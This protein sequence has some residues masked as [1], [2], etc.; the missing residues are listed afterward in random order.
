MEILIRFKLSV[1]LQLD[2]MYF[3][4]ILLIWTKTAQ[5]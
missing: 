4:T 5:L 3:F 2:F 1:E